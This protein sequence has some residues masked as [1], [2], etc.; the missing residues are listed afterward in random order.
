MKKKE[1]NS[2]KKFLIPG[3][4]LEILIERNMGCI[5]SDMITVQGYKV[6]YMYREECEASYDSGWRFFAGI[7]DQLYA[8][9][10][11][12]FSFY[13]LNTIANYDIDIIAFLELPVGTTL[14]RN[15]GKLILAK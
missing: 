4:K 3:E 10:P 8:D 2:E 13:N 9:N 6:G 5:A 11:D 14:E 1:N 7:E 12:N 15:N